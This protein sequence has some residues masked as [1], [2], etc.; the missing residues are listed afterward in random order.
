MKTL[1][2]RFTGVA[3]AVMLAS[4]SAM[5]HTVTTSAAFA[6]GGGLGMN[7]SEMDEMFARFKIVPGKHWYRLAGEKKH[8]AHRAS[9]KEHPV[10]PGP[11]LGDIERE[12]GVK[13]F[14]YIKDGVVYSNLKICAKLDNNTGVYKV[15]DHPFM[16]IAD[17][18]V[19]RAPKGH[20][21][22][23]YAHT[24]PVAAEDFPTAKLFKEMLRPFVWPVPVVEVAEAAPAPV[25]VPKK[26]KPKPKPAQ[27]KPAGN[28]VTV[29]GARIQFSF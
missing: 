10:L 13:F 17:K 4:L 6:E 5:F 22:D 24:M 7:H 19:I 12:L 16:E 25:V 21:L 18:C 15:A 9:E 11:L 26:A 29:N 1:S 2:P 14:K 3:M 28:V 20:L 27:K 23:D 8:M